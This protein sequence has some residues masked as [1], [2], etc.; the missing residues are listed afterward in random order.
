MLQ[1][2][3]LHPCCVILFASMAVAVVVIIWAAKL[4]S[5]MEGD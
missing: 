3:K 5:D 4:G 2:V 1:L